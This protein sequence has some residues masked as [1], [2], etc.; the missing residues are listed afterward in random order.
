MVRGMKKLDRTKFIKQ[1]SVPWLEIEACKVGK[2]M[3]YLKKYVLKLEKFKPLQIIAPYTNELVAINDKRPTVP[4][5]LTENNTKKKLILNPLLVISFDSLEENHIIELEN[6]NI[7]KENLHFSEL[8]LTYDNWRAD[9]VLKSILPEDK[10]SV[11]SYSLIGHI[12]HVNLRDHVLDYKSVIGE[13]LLDK[14]KGVKT[15]V[16]KIDIIDNKYRN[17]Q[18]EILC[19]ENNMIVEVRENHCIYTFDF[20]LVYWNPRLCTE[21]ER[22]VEM[23]KEGDILYDVCAG[24]G[25]FA[26]PAGKKKCTVLANDLNP[27]SF[28][29]LLSNVERNKVSSF[30]QAYN[31]DAR[32][33]IENDVKNHILLSWQNVKYPESIMHI[34]INLPAMAVTFLPSFVGLFTTEEMYAH[35]VKNYPIVHVYC[36]VKGDNPNAQAQK[37]VEENLGYFLTD[38]LKEIF[39]VRNVSTNKNM[40]R[41][42]FVLNQNVLSGNTIGKCSTN[43]TEESP[44]EPSKKKFIATH[45]TCTASNKSANPSL[46]SSPVITCR[47]IVY[48]HRLKCWYRHFLINYGR[49]LRMGKQKGTN[50]HKAVKN[51]FKVAGAKSLKLKHKAKA[52]SGQLKKGLGSLY[53]EE[54]FLHLH[55]GRVENHFEKTSLSTPGRDSNLDLPII[56]SLVYCESSTLDPAA[57]E[58]NEMNRK[59]TEEVDGQLAD[60]RTQLLQNVSSEEMKKNKKCAVIIK[61]TKPDSEP[62]ASETLNKLCEMQIAVSYYSLKL[63]A[64]ARITPLFLEIKKGTGFQTENGLHTRTRYKPFA[65]HIQSNSLFSSILTVSD[66]Q[67]QLQH[68]NSN[69]GNENLTLEE[70]GENQDHSTRSKESNIPSSGNVYMCPDCNKDSVVA[71]GDD[72]DIYSNNNNLYLL[73]LATRDAASKRMLNFRSEKGRNRRTRYKPSATNI[74]SNSL[75]SAILSVS[76]FHTQL[77]NWNSNFVNETSTLEEISEQW[78]HSTNS[79]DSNVP[80][81]GNVY[82]CPDCNKVYGWKQSLA[83]HMR[84]ECGK[85]PQFHCP[86]CSYKAKRNSH[87]KRHMKQHKNMLDFHSGKRLHA[88]I[89]YKSFSTNGKIEL[90]SPFSSIL[91]ISDFQSQLQNRNSNFGKL[92]TLK[93]IDEQWDHSTSSIDSNVPNSGNYGLLPPTSSSH[94]LATET[95]NLNQ[96]GCKLSFGSAYSREEDGAYKNVLDFH[97]GKRL[98]TRIRCKSFSTKD[99]IE[100]DSPFASILPISDIQSQLQNSN[101]NFGKLT[102]LEDINEQWDHSTSSMNSNVPNSGNVYVCPDCNKVYGWKQ[103][104]ALHM[105]LECGKEPQFHCP[106]CSYKAKRNSSLKSHMKQHN[107]KTYNFEDTNNA[108]NNIRRWSFSNESQLFEENASSDA[109]LFEENELNFVHDN[110][111]EYIFENTNNPQSLEEN[112]FNFVY[113]NIDEISERNKYP[114]NPPD[115]NEYIFENTNNNPQSIEENEF[116]FVYSNINTLSER[117][118][119]PRITPGL[120]QHSLGSEAHDPTIRASCYFL[121]LEQR[122]LLQGYLMMNYNPLNVWNSRER[123]AKEVPYG[124][125]ARV[126]E[127]GPTIVR[128]FFNLEFKG[129]YVCLKLPRL[130]FRHA[131]SILYQSMASKKRDSQQE[132]CLPNFTGRTSMRKRTSTHD[133]NSKTTKR[134]DPSAAFRRYA[135]PLA[136]GTTWTPR[137]A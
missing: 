102:T 14:V 51:V 48:I 16:N 126:R 94:R 124:S 133:I 109:K 43:L 10:D 74:Q 95:L 62:V 132:Q 68:C 135:P 110:N 46:P 23:L 50:K 56:A 118:K 7:S 38:N 119:Y 37:L 60:L 58:L 5:P 64:Y 115:I 129:L 98:Y 9:E 85:E 3:K 128:P 114:R 26:I 79:M 39:L 100:L 122:F 86:H 97:S 35:V 108:M 21:H 55:G 90:D 53:L 1:I 42:S 134:C 65:T 91:P 70:I 45:I 87:L 49:L 33:F 81:P 105:R 88:R 31:K 44:F 130:R 84:L 20:S 104:L 71:D 63:Y 13:V 112:E 101:S 18:M 47:A 32:I 123:V 2:A 77:Q 82:V 83:L 12:A 127:I 116:N 117:N 67:T 72:S 121:V 36:F 34:T 99:K 11:T 4:N 92:T 125:S 27:E 78:N 131:G 15:V 6:I 111:N 8:T 80:N 17:F 93:E 136:S 120:G 61:E 24:V 54:V 76:D 28:K 52:V 73:S 30:V 57:T 113:S 137:T 107:N 75:C 41:V 66:F 69:F 22:I 19:G 29:W 96:N 106:H 103:S 89:G 59:K 25:P 40:M